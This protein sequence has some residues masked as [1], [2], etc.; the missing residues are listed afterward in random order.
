MGEG[1]RE[2][3]KKMKSQSF[4]VLVRVPSLHVRLCVRERALRKQR[5]F[6]KEF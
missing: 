5:C 1:E 3:E 2:R 6:P 4:D